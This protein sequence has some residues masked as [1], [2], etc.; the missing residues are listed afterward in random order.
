MHALVCLHA[1]VC[2][3]ARACKCLSLGGRLGRAGKLLRGSRVRATGAAGAAWGAG[4]VL[5]GMLRSGLALLSMNGEIRVYAW[6][7]AFMYAVA[8]IYLSV[9][10]G[11]AHVCV[12]HACVW[13]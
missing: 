5:S 3:H 6:V 8:R 12:V 9:R 11:W 10:E 7:Y 13:R 1:H 2:L 4:A